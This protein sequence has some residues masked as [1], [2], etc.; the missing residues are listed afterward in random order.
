MKREH[1]RPR[2]WTMVAIVATLFM[3]LLFTGLLFAFRFSLHTEYVSGLQNRLRDALGSLRTNGFTREIAEQL[4]T[5]GVGVILYDETTGELIYRSS[6]KPHALDLR[7]IKSEDVLI[8]VQHTAFEA[9][10]LLVSGHLDRADGSFF[11]TDRHGKIAETA[12]EMLNGRELCLMGREGGALF[13]L[14]LPVESTNAAINLAIRYARITLAIALVLAMLVIF[15]ASRLAYQ[16]N[17]GMARIAGQ[18]AELDFSERCP[19]AKTREVDTLAVS[20]NRMADQLEKSIRELRQ[21]NELLQRE[22]AER[23]EQQRITTDLFAN[24]SHDLKTPIAIISGYAEGLQEGLA[25]TPEQRGKYYQMILT[26]SEHMQA[27]VSR[28]MTVRSLEQEDPVIEDFDL[29]AL[30][31]EILAPFQLEIERQGLQ[32]E[33]DYSAPL[34]VRTDFESVRQSILNYVQ[35][36]IYHINN[37]K[38]IRIIAKPQG[39]HIILRVQNSSA[40]IPE[41]EIPRLWEKLYRGDSA[42]PR[43]HG[44]AGLGLAIVHD[45]MKRLGQEFGFR[46]LD[47]MVEFY[48]CLPRATGGI[49]AA[50]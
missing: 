26:E 42:R 2:L 16:T 9:L 32:L 45:N 18:L 37:G 11:L 46:N 17:R 47:G 4:N 7:G 43:S 27:I 38:L 5:D 15:A 40:P 6:D 44:E 13:E 20:I 19:R 3:S 8:E 25:R 29:A 22:L 30:L 23:T 21:T 12:D 50:E 39:N 33:T 41:Q 34:P 1:R 10:S 48:L 49:G 31:N 36:A 14:Y 35:N 24:L 28:M